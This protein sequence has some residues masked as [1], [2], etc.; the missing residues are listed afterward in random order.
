MILDH[1]KGGVKSAE[2]R[3]TRAWNNDCESKFHIEFITKWN[4]APWE[5]QHMRENSCNCRDCSCNYENYKQNYESCATT[6]LLSEAGHCVVKI[7]E[8]FSTFGKHFKELIKMNSTQFD[9]LK[10]WI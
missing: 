8:K 4:L 2:D 3:V 1:V 6:D 5:H 7:S 10:M 9:K